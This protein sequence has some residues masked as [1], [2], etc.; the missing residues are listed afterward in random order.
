MESSQPELEQADTV[1]PAMQ[2]LTVAGPD[3][4]EQVKAANPAE[5]I[6]PVAV[7][8]PSDQNEAVESEPMDDIEFDSG[9][10]PAIDDSDEE[11][12]DLYNF[13]TPEALARIMA[14]KD[15]ADISPLP[16]TPADI[17]PVP[18]TAASGKLATGAKPLP[19]YGAKRNALSRYFH[20]M[21]EYPLLTREEE[22]EMTR[23][24]MK[25]K[26]A[27]L[28]LWK[29]KKI[30]L[31]PEDIRD[32]GELIE[33]KRRLEEVYKG[34]EI[35][36][37]RLVV[38]IARQSQSRRGD[39]HLADLIQEGNIGL[40]RATIGFDPERGYKFSTYA[41]WWI[42]HYIHRGVSDKGRT[43]RW[44]VHIQEASRRYDKT[45][46]RLKGEQR[47]AAD[48]EPSPE[49]MS[50]ETGIGSKKVQSLA[51][52]AQVTHSLNTPIKDGDGAHF[53]DVVPD[54]NSE[55]VD[56][57]VIIKSTK[58]FAER[59]L[60]T[61]TPREQF[62]IKHRFGINGSAEGAS[63]RESDGK[64]LEQVGRLLKVTRERIRQIEGKALEK[65]R[66]AAAK[67][68]ESV[69]EE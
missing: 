59:L 5:Q 65:M 55:P 62:V 63:P 54:D 44:P 29:R 37:L 34:F 32:D 56:S 50:E 3:P 47:I 51:T 27:F 23:G 21:S 16:E 38:K 43:I 24:I 46:G 15:T 26:K 40:R 52:L 39:L 4:S 68:E 30:E 19:D 2:I 45:A 61:L 13:A 8:D 22:L 49:I 20:E 58:G 42:R 10:F 6:D 12:T 66:R 18:E 11:E 28:E 60:S 31:P 64:T 69:K 36:N 53:I 33:A 35:H 48:C 7:Q 25:A 17:G 14:S 57:G 41:S 1:E 9:I 67:M